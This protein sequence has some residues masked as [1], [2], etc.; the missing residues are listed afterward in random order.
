MTFG[1]YVL[2]RRSEA[3]YHFTSST[4]C[5]STSAPASR[6]SL[7]T[8]YKPR[9]AAS[10]NGIQQLP[11]DLL[12]ALRAMRQL[13]SRARTHAVLLSSD[14]V[15]L[16]LT[17]RAS[18]VLVIPPVLLVS[19]LRRHPRRAPRAA[20]RRPR[21]RRRRAAGHLSCSAPPRVRARAPPALRPH[22]GHLCAPRAPSRWHPPSTAVRN[23]PPTRTTFA[24]R[25]SSCTAS[26]ADAWIA[27]VLQDASSV[28][29]PITRRRAR[30]LSPR[31]ASLLQALDATPIAAAIA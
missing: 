7:H 1:C 24:T 16:G 22:A 3:E 12:W 29:A 6:S 9:Y 31:V 18:G 11:Q 10:C 13:S 8:V 17:T 4:L 27:S 14:M 25:G 23:Q 5:T 15:R 19:R 26:C 30:H 2:L 21:S 28:F 20:L